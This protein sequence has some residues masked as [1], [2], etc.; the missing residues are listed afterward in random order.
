MTRIA[1][2][3][4]YDGSRYHGWQTQQKGIASVQLAVE[5]ALAKVAD[6]PVSVSCAGR[7]DA[8]VHAT[9]QVIHFDTG[10]ER[11][12]RGWVFGANTNLPADIAIRWARP[13]SEAFHARFGARAR[14][15]RYVIYNHPIRP[16][17][18]N[19]QLTWNYRPLDVARMRAALPALLGTH[20]F[21]SYRGIHCQAKSPVKTLH[22][23]ALY[24]QGPLL[25]LEAEAN[26]FLM[27][28][29]RN[30]VGVLMA[31]GTGKAEPEWA[32]QVLAARD[33]RQGGVTAPPFGLYLVNVDYDSS[34]GLPAEQLGPQWL[35]HDLSAWSS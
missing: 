30:I 8:G 28:M 34:F 20:D 11:T 3:V 18:Y 27:H 23:L 17:L 15:Y 22:H 13:V 33:R 4:E 32:G 31:I 24:Q 12:E 5:T 26:A 35:P 6:H 9:G 25:V 14:R 19:R 21:T 1:L 10:A 29:V 7:T 2:G 16:G